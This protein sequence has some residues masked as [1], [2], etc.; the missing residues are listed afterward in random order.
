VGSFK[1]IHH[2]SFKIIIILLLA[3]FFSQV[4][5]RLSK[6]KESQSSIIYT[7]YLTFQ[8]LSSPETSVMKLIIITV[9]GVCL[10]S[11]FEGIRGQGVGMEPAKPQSSFENQLVARQLGLDF[12]CGLDLNAFGRVAPLKASGEAN[13]CLQCRFNAFGIISLDFSFAN[14]LASTISSRGVS[15]RDASILQ[16]HLQV[17]LLYTPFPESSFR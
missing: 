1:K 13:L 10:M 8:P 11:Q 4:K 6:K 12:G 14:A 17:I 16:G 15:A 9:I 3:F 2:H 7:N 5:N